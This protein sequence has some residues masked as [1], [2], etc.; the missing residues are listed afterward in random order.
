MVPIDQEIP[1]RTIPRAADDKKLGYAPLLI[2]ELYTPRGL[3]VLSTRRIDL[4]AL[5]GGGEGPAGEAD[6]W[7]WG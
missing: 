1:F 5:G 6:A 7:G 4:P 2:V 3:L